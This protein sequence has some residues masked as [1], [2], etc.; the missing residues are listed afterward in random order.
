MASSRTP[1]VFIFSERYRNHSYGSQHPLSIP[2]V[3]LTHDL[4]QAYDGFV[5]GEV[6]D[7]KKASDEE[8]QW[9]HTA[10]YIA[11]M[12]NVEANSKVPA[13][14]RKKHNIGNF[15]NPY[16]PGFFSTPATA[17][18]GSIQAAECM[19]DGYVAFSPAGGMH[20]AMPDSANG[21]CFFNDP[22]LAIL[23]LVKEGLK[24]LYVDID[25]HHGDGVEYAFKDNS[26][27]T[28]FSLHMAADYAY[29]FKGGAVEQIGGLGNAINLPLPKNTTDS[30]YDWAFDQVWQKI[31]ACHEFDAV[32][33]QAGT[34]ILRPDPLGKFFISTQQFLKTVSTIKNSVPT[35]NKIPQLVVLGGGGYHPLSLSRCWLGVWGVLTN[36]HFSTDMPQ[37]ASKL[38]Q[39][40]DWDMDED[41]DWYDNFFRSRL[42]TDYQ[43]DIRDKV[44]ETVSQ[45]LNSHPIFNR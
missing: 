31:I 20:H 18:G 16:F 36:Q 2:R 3:S 8:L 44:L 1:A 33:L 41:E 42:D 25:A 29:P 43:S 12:K 27:V 19:L 9:F 34:D 35:K 5:P 30:E 17:T 28:T 45:L 14:Y 37:G 11:A 10:E 24:V 32:V 23:R 15:E 13:E 40:V 4:I 26:M 38:L 7:S 6:R 21:F 39:S 22:V